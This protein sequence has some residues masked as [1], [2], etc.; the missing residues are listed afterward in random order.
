MDDEMMI[1]LPCRC[2]VE[3]KE[4]NR[5]GEDTTEAGRKPAGQLAFFRALS[6]WVLA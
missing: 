3:E 4:D 6:A 1:E 5:V 2:F